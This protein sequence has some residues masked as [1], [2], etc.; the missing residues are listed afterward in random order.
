MDPA[1]VRTHFGGASE[2]NAARTRVSGQGVKFGCHAVFGFQVLA[3]TAAR[4]RR[5]TRSLSR[6]ALGRRVAHLDAAQV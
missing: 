2:A 5:N 4:L 3:T 6:S 1:G